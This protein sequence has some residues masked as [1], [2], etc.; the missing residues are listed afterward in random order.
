[1]IFLTTIFARFV[2]TSIN[3]IFVFATLRIIFKMFFTIK[4]YVL[5]KKFDLSE[6]Y[7]RVEPILVLFLIIFL[8]S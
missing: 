3:K 1:M 6:T 7:L 4:V 8:N 5:K 2:Y